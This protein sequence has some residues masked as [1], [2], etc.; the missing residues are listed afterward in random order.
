MCV[1][2]SSSLEV[3]MKFIIKG[4]LVF[5]AIISANVYGAGLESEMNGF[6]LQLQ[7]GWNINRGTA[8][9]NPVCQ[10]INMRKI[11]EMIV[12]IDE[13]TMAQ[14]YRKYIKRLFIR[15][16]IYGLN[17]DN[18]PVMRGVVIKETILQDVT[19]RYG[20]PVAQ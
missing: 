2:T 15:P 18:Q 1:Y 5:I 19:V 6:S 16:Y 13:D 7:G 17:R 20:S 3:Y 10:A 14:T 11:L 9:D 4:L 8:L 12:E